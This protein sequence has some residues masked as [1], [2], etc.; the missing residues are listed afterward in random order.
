MYGATGE[1]TTDPWF[2]PFEPGAVTTITRCDNCR[3]FD[4]VDPI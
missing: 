1:P 4:H 3:P 2:P